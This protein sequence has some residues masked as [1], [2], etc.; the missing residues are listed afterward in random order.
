[1]KLKEN[2]VICGQRERPRVAFLARTRDNSRFL[3]RLHQKK[4]PQRTSFFG[5]EGNII[6]QAHSVVTQ[7]S[8]ADKGNV[9]A[10]RAS[11]ESAVIRGFSPAVHQKRRPN[12][13][14]FLAQ[15]AGFEPALRFSH[16]TPLAGEPLEP[17]GYFCMAQYLSLIQKSYITISH[18]FGLVKAFCRKKQKIFFIFW[19]E[20]AKMQSARKNIK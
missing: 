7:N 5:A 13:R 15:K 11:R 9:R 1:M 6:R 20:I 17:L 16:T 2:C 3:T 4:T 12:G 8:V 14:P 10:L 19:T 18:F